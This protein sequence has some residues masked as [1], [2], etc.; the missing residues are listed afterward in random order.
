[1][2]SNLQTGLAFSLEPERHRKQMQSG[3]VMFLHAGSGPA[4]RLPD[5]SQALCRALL[6]P[7]L[8]QLPPLSEL[9]E[10][11]LQSLSTKVPLNPDAYQLAVAQDPE[12]AKDFS[13]GQIV[14][15]QLQLKIS[16]IILGDLCIGSEVMV[17]SAVDAC[18]VRLLLLIDDLLPVSAASYIGYRLERDQADSTSTMTILSPSGQSLRPDLVLRA[19]DQERMLFKAEEKSDK[20]TLTEAKLVSS[21]L[22]AIPLWLRIAAK[23]L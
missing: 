10:F 19:K 3:H 17:A 2:G 5:P 14:L 4:A 16:A 12:L 15:D 23:G 7:L 6:E 11:L 9:D 1:M 22:T 21:G 20:F 18:L 8:P 13:E